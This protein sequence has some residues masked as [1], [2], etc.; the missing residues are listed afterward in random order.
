MKR[1]IIK[2]GHSTLTVTLP[3]EWTKKFNLS[4]R[5]EIELIEKDNGLFFSTE[6]R[7]ED[8]KTCFNISEMDVPTIWKYFMGAYRTGYDEVKVKFSSDKKLEH[9]YKF[10]TQHHIDN[11]YT[12]KRGNEITVTEFLHEIVN[13]FIGFEIVSHGKDFIIIKEMSEPSSKEFESALRRVFLL[14]QQMIEETCEAID[15]KNPKM[16]SHIHDVDINLDKF[17]DYCI[18]ILT[19]VGN[20]NSKET[21]LLS[22]ILNLLELL[23]D[24]FK[25]ISIHLI[26]DYSKSDFKHIKEIA[27]S[28]K[29]QINLYYELFYKFDLKKVIRISEIDY[30]RYLNVKKVF[31]KTSKEEDEIFHHLRIITRYLIALTEL[32]IE[33][34]FLKKE[35]CLE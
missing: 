20:K 21:A 6:K 29:E 1:K 34:E 35:E 27:S 7:N 5:D 18:R 3:S 4:A 11:K 10:M 23:G 14:V 2:Q 17:H 12:D 33:L 19:K 22:S 32:R 30:Y 9:P 16:L 8:K 31:R 26:Y 25:N 28:I 15:T 13:R 24:E